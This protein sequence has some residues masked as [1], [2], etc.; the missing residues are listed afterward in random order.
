MIDRITFRIKDYDLEELKKRLPLDRP[1]SVN[2]ETNEVNNGNTLIINK[3]IILAS[4]N[5]SLKGSLHKYKKG[6]YK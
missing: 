1:M 6:G 2:R 5:L 3:F 4:K